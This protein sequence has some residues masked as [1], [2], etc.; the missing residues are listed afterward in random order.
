MPITLP[1]LVAHIESLGW[2]HSVDAEKDCI[3]LGFA[4]RHHVDLEGDKHV[5][6]YVERAAEG[7]YVEVYL[8]RLYN[9]AN[10]KFKGATLAVLAEIAFRTRSLQCEYDSQDG[11]VRYSVDTWLLDNTL[12]VA[13]LEMMVRIALKL[14]E[15]FEPVVR[16]AM[17]TGRVDFDLAVKPQ[18]EPPQGS[19]P[20]LP[21]EIAELVAK[22]GGLEAL[23]EAVE[24]AVSANDKK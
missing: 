17:E 19:P 20:A 16:C 9:L 8:P 11:E 5:L 13:Q 2:K 6:V 10:C 4:T 14:L 7:R 3:V 24:R 15:E 18:E 23:R 12:T 22:A 1:E 21:P